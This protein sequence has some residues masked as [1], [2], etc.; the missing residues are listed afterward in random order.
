MVRKQRS[1]QHHRQTPR[2]L[3]PSVWIQNFPFRG[4][5]APELLSWISGRHSNGGALSTNVSRREYTIA[6]CGDGAVVVLALG[7]RSSG[8][9][10]LPF[11]R[12]KKG[13]GMQERVYLNPR[14]RGGNSSE[15][16]N[17]PRQ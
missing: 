15:P 3:E 12:Q 2:S 1:R 4:K 13:G 14:K 16:Y 17:Q 11:S 5:I 10:G 8:G 9:G 6:G 7:L